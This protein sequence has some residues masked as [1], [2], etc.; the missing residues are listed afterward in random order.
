[1]LITN[2]VS[3][4]GMKYFGKI[5]EIKGCEEANIRSPHN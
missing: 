3:D 5:E 1:M 2:K 4:L